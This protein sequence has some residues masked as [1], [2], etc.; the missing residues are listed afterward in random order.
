[1]NSKL[2]LSCAAMLW[3]GMA[4]ASDISNP[5]IGLVVSPGDFQ[6]DGL[7]AR[8]NGSLTSALVAVL[9]PLFV[10]VMV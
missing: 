7:R 8:G 1:M 10:T 2:V 4:A 5:A 9:G 6:I 3:I